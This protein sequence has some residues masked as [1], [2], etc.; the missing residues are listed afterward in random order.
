LRFVPAHPRNP[1]TSE[2]R[3]APQAIARFKAKVE[4]VHSGGPLGAR[5]AAPT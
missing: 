4:E 3:I 5:G 1:D 2:K